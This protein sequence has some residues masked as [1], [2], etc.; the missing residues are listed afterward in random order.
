MASRK[1]RPR[2]RRVRIGHVSVY[3]HHGAFWIYFREKGKPQRRCLGKDLDEARA[4]AAQVNAQLATRQRTQ[5]AFDAVSAAEMVRRWLHHHE[6]VLRSAVA[7]R[8]RYRTAAAHLLRFVQEACPA[9]SAHEVDA[10]QFVEYLRSVQVTPNGHANSARRRL[11]DKGI[12]FVLDACRSLYNFAGK[13]RLTDDL[14]GGVDR[15][16]VGG[17]KA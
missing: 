15:G 11:R 8:D 7:T 12:K 4:V 3:E 6:H 5:Y 2:S 16:D 1:R 9:C 17:C 14:N 10:E 13:H